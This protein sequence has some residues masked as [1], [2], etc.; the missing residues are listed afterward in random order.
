MTDNLGFYYGNRKRIDII[1]YSDDI[2]K[3]PFWGGSVSP[4]SKEQ[5][6]FVTSITEILYWESRASK[7]ITLPISLKLL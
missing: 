6:I 3:Q 4:M 2:V 1:K 5:T 7:C